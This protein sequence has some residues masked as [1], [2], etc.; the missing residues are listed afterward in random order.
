MAMA[1]KSKLPDTLPDL[2]PGYFSE[3]QEEALAFREVACSS[4]NPDELLKRFANL[5]QE[6]E[7]LTGRRKKEE[8]GLSRHHSD[9]LPAARPQTKDA[10]SWRSATSDLHAGD[11]HSASGSALTAA[12]EMFLQACVPT[13]LSA[14]MITM[15]GEEIESSLVSSYQRIQ[16]YFRYKNMMDDLG[17]HF[18]KL[19]HA[20]I[21]AE[22]GVMNELAKASN[23]N[24]PAPA[25][26]RGAGRGK[27]AIT[28]SPTRRKTGGDTATSKW[29]KARLPLI[30]KRLL[31]NSEA[32]TQAPP[33]QQLKPQANQA[34][35]QAGLGRLV[36]R[37][38]VTLGEVT[39]QR[40]LSRKPTVR[41]R[42]RYLSD[43]TDGGFSDVSAT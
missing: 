6:M 31:R 26:P 40:P 25:S 24:D 42:S 35:H 36:R 13:G 39:P 28:A 3:S 34:L 38:S 30:S 17:D 7:A 23:A 14:R 41:F 29:S 21:V 19:H 11:P 18:D 32:Q 16:N 12:E 4:G 1:G 20:A 10:K 8:E 37:T 22:D 27:K 9:T 43:M 2:L 5:A 15:A 33:K